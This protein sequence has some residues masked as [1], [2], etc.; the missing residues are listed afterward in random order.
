MRLGKN[1]GQ[2]GGDAMVT[3]NGCKAVQGK[4]TCKAPWTRMGTGLSA[5]LCKQMQ[6]VKNSI[7]PS[8]TAITRVQ[9]PSGTPTKQKTYRK[10]SNLIA[11][12]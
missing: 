3:I 9:I 5:S 6:N 7:I 10:L 2:K 8:F 12:R 11:V 4:A 1:T